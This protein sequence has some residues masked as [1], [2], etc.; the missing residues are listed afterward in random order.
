[1]SFQRR[2]KRNAERLA[3]NRAA[4]KSEGP[5]PGDVVVGCV[6]KPDPRLGSH[7]FYVGTDTGQPALKLSS[8]HTEMAKWIFLCQEC[9]DKFGD[10]MGDALEK[11]EVPLTV[12]AT[13]RKEDGKLTI[14]PVTFTKNEDKN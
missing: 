6:H 11:K 9:N 3:R 8:P 10:R 1:M 12:V 5:Q 13:W 4:I 14:I 2:M 7:C